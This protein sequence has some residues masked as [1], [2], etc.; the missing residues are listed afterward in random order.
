V[1]AGIYLAAVISV[2]SDYHDADGFTECSASGSGTCS[3]LQDVI[4]AAFWLGGGL[5][6][7]SAL[8]CLGALIVLVARSRGQAPAGDLE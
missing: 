1:L 6:L 3:T 8:F 4:S 5:L 7:A 2:A